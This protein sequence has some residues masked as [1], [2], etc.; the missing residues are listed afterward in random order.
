MGALI[1]DAKLIHQQSKNGSFTQDLHVAVTKLLPNCATCFRK[2]EKL[3]L[4]NSDERDKTEIAQLS[5]T[6]VSIYEDF[7]KI[8]GH[9][10]KI[11]GKK[12]AKRKRA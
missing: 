5:K 1:T 9:F 7:N 12:S 2:L 11:T 6:L 8:E 3:Y 10:N 4:T